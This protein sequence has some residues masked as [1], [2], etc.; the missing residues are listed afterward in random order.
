MFE[1]YIPL[2]NTKTQYFVSPRFTVLSLNSFTE[3]DCVDVTVPGVDLEHFVLYVVPLSSV[4]CI[5]VPQESYLG[6]TDRI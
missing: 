6:Y 2:E 5:A 1:A 4:I 3:V